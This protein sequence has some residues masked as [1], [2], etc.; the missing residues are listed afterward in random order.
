MR[1]ETSI[2]EQIDWLQ[3]TIDDEH[4]HHLNLGYDATQE[5]SFV[6]NYRVMTVYRDTHASVHYGH[7][8]SKKPL[9]VLNG[10]ACA[11]L[12]N[13]MSMREHIDLVLS[14]GA[15]VT[16]MDLAYTIT[17]AHASFFTPSEFASWVERGL[18]SGSHFERGG[19][20]SV[21][22]NETRAHETVYVGDLQ[23]RGK[24][25][26]LRVYD[27][28]LELHDEP[29]VITRVECEE[30]RDYA[31]VAARRFANEHSIRE[32]ISQRVQV[33]AQ[34]W[35]QTIGDNGPILRRY[36]DEHDDELKDK[37]QWLKR[38]AL[39]ALADAISDD[40]ING[41]D[42]HRIDDF[43]TQ[44]SGKVDAL[45]RQKTHDRKVNESFNVPRVKL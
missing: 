19:S 24:N 12:S 36:H 22:N 37:W 7:S 14:L 10:R 27:K 38:S 45:M 31:K 26:I 33:N 35:R 6:R 21:Y 30:K 4:S 8:I 5:S 39:P 23:K 20:K 32:L 44:L 29:G 43:F 17:H 16:R 1:Y 18:V 40:L 28:G 13:E 42:M 3:Y 2:F 34:K 41:H 15:T 9:V 25:G 11:T